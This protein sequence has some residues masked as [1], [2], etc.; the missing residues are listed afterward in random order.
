M[1]LVLQQTFYALTCTVN[2]QS[3][4]L[5][6]IHEFELATRRRPYCP[7]A[8]FIIC[9][10]IG[11]SAIMDPSAEYSGAHSASLESKCLV[12]GVGDNA[13]SGSTE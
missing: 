10:D 11:A 5:G 3:K 13:R 9:M 8:Q 7:S 12:R 6:Q 4:G 1:P 2:E